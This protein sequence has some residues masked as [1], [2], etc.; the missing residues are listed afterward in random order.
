MTLFKKS[1]NKKITKTFNYSV[2]IDNEI[3]EYEYTFEVKDNLSE[4]KILK[5]CYK[6]FIKRHS[7]DMIDN[8]VEVSLK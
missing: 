5:K 2:K 6:Q 8:I 3:K 4:E 7:V 1:F